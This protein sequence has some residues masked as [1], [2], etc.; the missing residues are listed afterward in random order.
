MLTIKGDEGLN[1]VTFVTFFL[2]Q[3]HSELIAGIVKEDLIQHI[4]LH[5][6]LF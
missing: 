3:L 1:F 2:R 5:W 6:L 4:A